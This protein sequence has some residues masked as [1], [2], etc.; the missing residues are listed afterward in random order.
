[1]VTL[2][3]RERRTAGQRIADDLRYKIL[4]GQD[5][6]LPGVL[7]PSES[8]MAEQYQ[9]SRP[10]IRQALAQL[11]EEGLLVTVTGQGSKVAQRP[12]V[13]PD[14][15]DLDEAPTEVACLLELPPGTEVV[16][17]RQ[18]FYDAGQP[19]RLVLTYSREQAA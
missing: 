18:I 14:V 12:P 8:R 5:G 7:L 6:L 4:R 9:V 3:P 1:M 16:R 11:R 13:D 10:T 17:R 15:T 19:V 2:T